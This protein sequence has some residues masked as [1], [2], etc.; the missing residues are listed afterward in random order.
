MTETEHILCV[1]LM[2]LRRLL[3]LC[4]KLMGRPIE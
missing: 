4:I 1:K 2:I 3:N